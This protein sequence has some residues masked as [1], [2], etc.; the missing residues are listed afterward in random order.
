MVRKILIMGL[1]GAGKTTLAYALSD[2][3]NAI[4]IDG[5]DIRRLHQHVDFSEAGRVQQAMTIRDHCEMAMA[6]GHTAIASFVCPTPECRAAF[7]GQ[8]MADARF[9][10]FVD[11]IVASEFQDT[12]QDVRP[13]V[14][15]RL[16]GRARRHCRDYPSLT[17]ST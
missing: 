1:P 15:V 9:E 7:W 12:Q 10:I 16:P 4:V 14:H 6:N 8:T 2:K 17:S 5:D 13:A 11:R 3:L